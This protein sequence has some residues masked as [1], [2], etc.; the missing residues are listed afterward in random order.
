MSGVPTFNTGGAHSAHAKPECASTAREPPCAPTADPQVNPDR[1]STAHGPSTC[2]EEA[3]DWGLLPRPTL[4]SH[5]RVPEC[6]AGV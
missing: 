5:R 1:H 3:G 6:A 2:L 4:T